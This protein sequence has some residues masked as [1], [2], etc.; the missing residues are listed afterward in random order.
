MNETS[1]IFP[2]LRRTAWR[3][4][5]AAVRWTRAVVREIKA[6]GLDYRAMS[7]V[8]TSLLALTPLLAVSFSVFKA[9]GAHGSIEPLLQELLEP[10]GAQGTAVAAFLVDSV[11]KIKVGVLGGVGV[12]LLFYTSL[13]M[14][15]KIEESF[16]H[17]W[18][19]R[20]SRSV[21]RRLGDYLSFILV[22][23]WLLVV[24][25]G[26]L[27]GALSRPTPFSGALGIVYEALQTVA[28]DLFV[29]AA[30]S[31]AYRYIPNARVKTA[32]A[33]CGGAVAGL[34]W[35]AAGWGFAAFVSGSAQYH[36]VYSSF[37]ILILFMIWLYVSWLI[38][39]LGV[40][41]AFFHQHP[42]Y[43]RRMGKPERL[44]IAAFER[45]GMSVMYCIGQ[46]FYRGETPW[47]REELAER[48]D[49]PENCVEES[50]ALLR[51]GGMILCLDEER[52]LHIPARDLSNIALAEIL[53]ALRQTQAA[54]EKLGLPTAHDLA[55]RAEAAARAAH[56]KTSLRDWILAQ[57]SQSPESLSLHRTEET[58][59]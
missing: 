1:N 31:F 57:E 17:V 52:C 8:Y 4:A 16:N 2:Q 13:S 43:F 59:E 24:A 54:D 14:L 39:L 48:L 53:D 6:G 33:V 41:V 22:G 15:D 36:A 32:S 56:G 35:K 9:F 23:P 49:L 10:L 7:L 20:A 26:G 29:I 46:R 11:K 21:A 18:R 58:E 5:I 19:A 44:G 50:L 38:V 34:A 28:P 47:D 55:R 37:A 45:A 42:R 25:F 3:Q 27:S 51:A 12:L 30:F 40:Q